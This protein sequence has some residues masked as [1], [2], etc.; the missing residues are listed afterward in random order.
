MKL[1]QSLLTVAG[2]AALLFGGQASAV[3]VGLE[4]MLLIDVSGSVNLTEYGL[5]KQG[6]V[7]AFNSSAVQ[8]AIL[9]S[10]GGSIAVTYIEWSGNSQLSTQVGWTLINSAA[11]ANSFAAL[12]NGTSRAFNGNTAIQDAIGNSYKDF[13]TEVGGKSNGFE[14]RRQ[15]IDVSG[16]GADNDSSSFSAFGGGRNAAISAGVDAINGIYIVGEGGLAAYYGNYV[17]G[18]ATGFTMAANSFGDFA[19]AI[20]A[21]LVKEISQT[22]P[23]PTSLALVGLA[24]LGAGAVRRRVTQS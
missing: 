7:N 14:S 5:Q 20:E 15:V 3:P 8:N 12:I 2:A 1:K 11:S 6:Y 4:L 16:D 24:L 10:Q 9:G 18:G 19:T 17:K 22:V 13:G 21:K 23:E